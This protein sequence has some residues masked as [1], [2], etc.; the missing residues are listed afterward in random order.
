M[1]CRVGRTADGSWS[2]CRHASGLTRDQPARAGRFFTAAGRAT[3]SA[4]SRAIDAPQFAIDLASVHALGLQ[5]RQ[6]LIEGAVGIPAIEP[7]LNGLPGAERL[8]Q[9]TPRGAG[10]LDVQNAVH[11]QPT[12][13]RR[14]P[15]LGRRREYVG[16]AVP[17]R[18][19]QTM[20]LHRTSSVTAPAHNPSMP[21]NP[22]PKEREVFRRSLVLQRLIS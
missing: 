22:D 20:P 17:L 12:I 18:I 3:G 11:H 7:V 5:T 4:N 13:R 14:M 15:R 19:R 10:A 21:A 8:R 2:K 16:N 1:D 9:I 6:Y